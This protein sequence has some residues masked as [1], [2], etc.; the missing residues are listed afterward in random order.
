MAAVSGVCA[1]RA[2]RDPDVNALLWTLQ[3]VLALVF[4]G[5]GT[6]KLVVLRERLTQMMAFVAGTP[7]RVVRLIGGLE[8]FGTLGLVLPAVTGTLPRL[9]PLAAA[10]LALTM[11]GAALTNLRIGKP[12]HIAANA[13]LFAAAFVA[14][15]RFVLVPLGG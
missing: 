4:A 15:E 2:G 3:V 13:V 5:A 11:V 12:G 9:T 10:G 7:Q 6:A 14:Y 1:A 8:L